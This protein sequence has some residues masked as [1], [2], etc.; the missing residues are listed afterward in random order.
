MLNRLAP[1]CARGSSRAITRASMFTRLLGVDPAA[2]QVDDC[3]RRF[4]G[5]SEIALAGISHA[6]GPALLGKQLVRT[7]AGWSRIGDYQYRDAIPPAKR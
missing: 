5:V 1:R 3:R 7:L 6:A 4:A 2:K